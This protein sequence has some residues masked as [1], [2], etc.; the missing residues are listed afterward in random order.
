MPDDGLQAVDA[1]WTYGAGT[2]PLPHRLIPDSCP[3]LMIRI[4]RDRHGDVS[5]SAL[6]LVGGEVHSTW[7]RPGPLELT[8]GL[9]VKPEFAISVLGIRPSELRGGFHLPPRTVIATFGRIADTAHFHAP[10][11]VASKLCEAARALTH[12]SDYRDEK[13]TAHAIRQS[14]GRQEIGVLARETGVSDRALRRRFRDR[15]GIGPKAYARL[16]RLNAVIAGADGL[17][18]PNWAQLAA[19]HGFCDQSHLIRDCL[20]IMGVP[21]ATLHAERR[22]EAEMSNTIAP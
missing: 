4:R 18:R 7:Y 9:R 3:S 13:L 21:P 22:N 5:D 8:I 20:A 19:E 2:R 11:T 17:A 16:V 12:T 6:F 14:E 10:D 15:T 1:V